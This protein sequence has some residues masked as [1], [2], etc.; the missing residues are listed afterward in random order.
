MCINGQVCYLH[1]SD[2]MFGLLGEVDE[3]TFLS[4]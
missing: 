2:G 3:V 4:L 1:S